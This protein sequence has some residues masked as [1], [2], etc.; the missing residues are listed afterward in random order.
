MRKFWTLESLGQAIKRK[1]GEVPAPHLDSLSSGQCRLKLS[2]LERFVAVVD[3]FP[4]HNIP[5][6]SQILR[7][8]IVV[9][10]VVG[11]LPHVIAED[12]KQALRQRVVLIRRADDLNFAAGLA[13]KPYPTTAELLGPSVVEFGFE[14][15][16]IAEGFFYY[17]SDRTVRFTAGFRLHDLP[18]HGV[19]HM[20]AAVVANRSTNIFR[21]GIQLANKILRAL[22]LQLGIF[23][24]RR[25]QVL[26]VRAVMHVMMQ[27]H[28][29]GINSWFQGRIVIRQRG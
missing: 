20:A 25:I 16:E 5:P 3:F 2:R 13:G 28:R 23:L 11:V 10:Q 22:R 8:A 19:I 21:H 29:L 12:R 1:A 18:K 7:P 15:V 26:H 6:R 14:V 24:Q 9:F 4:V 17:F 27:L